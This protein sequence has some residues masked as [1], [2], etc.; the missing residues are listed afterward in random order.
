[1]AITHAVAVRNTLATAINT[2]VNAGSSYGKFKI[3][4]AIDGLLA[5]VILQDPAFGSSTAGVVTLQGT[6]LSAT[7]SG[8]GAATKFTVTDSDD[9]VIFSGSVGTSGTDAIID[10]A[11]IASGQ[12]VRITACTYAAAA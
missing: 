12:T 10:N 4:T 1:M 8:S 6:P 11:V 2:A 9:T 3:Y 7:A 5:T